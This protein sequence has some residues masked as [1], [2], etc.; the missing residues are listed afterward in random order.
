M[1]ARGNFRQR[2]KLLD[3]SESIERRKW[4]ND[5]QKPLKDSYSK[6][7]AEQEAAFR[8]DFDSA[9]AN[10]SHGSKPGLNGLVGLK[11]NYKSKWII[12][13]N[14]CKSY[15]TVIFCF[16]GAGANSGMFVAL[17]RKLQL[18]QV[19]LY[20]IHYPG[21]LNRIQETFAS[22]TRQI[23]YSVR[24]EMIQ[25]EIL[26]IQKSTENDIKKIRIILL[27][28]CVGALICFD[29]SRVLLNEGYRI[30]QLLLLAC[31][32]PVRTMKYNLTL[33]VEYEERFKKKYPYVYA[34]MQKQMQLQGVS[35]QHSVTSATTTSSIRATSSPGSKR[36]GG[37]GEGIIYPPHYEEMLP[38]VV[39]YSS[40][41]A[42]VS[43]HRHYAYT[44]PQQQQR[45][46]QQL[47]GTGAVVSAS[48]IVSVPTKGL[49]G[50][51]N[52]NSLKNSSSN[53]NSNNS[54]NSS[55]VM[56]HSNQHISSNNS[57]TSSVSRIS[58]ASS[59]VSSSSSTL[60]T[61]GNNNDQHHLAATSRS[62]QSSPSKSQAGASLSSSA[63]SRPATTTGSSSSSSG[64]VS[65]KATV[66][67]LYNLDEDDLPSL[68]PIYHTLQDPLVAIQHLLRIGAVPYSLTRRKDLLTYFVTIFQAD[69][70]LLENYM[71]EPP[72]IPGQIRTLKNIA[73]ETF[74]DEEIQEFTE[75]PP[76]LY[77]I[78][79]PFV[80]IYNTG[81]ILMTENDVTAW[82][83]LS[84]S[85]H[86]HH[87][88]H[89]DVT[90]LLEQH[91]VGEVLTLESQLVMKAAAGTGDNDS[92]D[93]DIDDHNESHK[94]KEMRRKQTHYY[95][96]HPETL[97]ILIHK[98]ENIRENEL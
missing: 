89:T 58:Q 16:P 45:Q 13:M 20:G 34:Q 91:A 93:S 77:K 39:D 68:D 53:S 33:L 51:K 25:M 6:N 97:Q 17:A 32:S 61:R 94:E 43:F 62:N 27:G 10:I 2:G 54:N 73:D 66:Y 50:S 59:Q 19:K 57:I 4:Y 14:T 75:M 1:A 86:D 60:I 63:S 84:S 88:L 85:S 9:S 90:A 47:G 78:N 98:I 21:H 82:S 71:I 35:D 41:N 76:S 44:K 8:E 24:E 22:S 30:D 70:A 46:Q 26:R 31:K 15:D 37:G 36:G 49:L 87:T 96:N 80:T 3:D 81:D 28:Y 64:R 23:V 11:E 52:Q 38:Q 69:M 7:K 92:D 95:M 29:L 42:T 48:S 83:L 79:I 74:T 65:S 55:P 18:Q 72:F 12:P 67:S 40:L 5:M 56:K